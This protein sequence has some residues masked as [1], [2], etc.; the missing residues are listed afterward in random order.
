MEKAFIAFEKVRQS[1][2]TNMYD[3]TY[4]CS[5]AGITVEEYHY[6]LENYTELLNQFN[7]QLKSEETKFELSDKE[8]F[9]SAYD[10]VKE[11]E[12]RYGLDYDIV[13][14]GVSMKR[15]YDDSD[16]LILSKGVNHMDKFLEFCDDNEIKEFYITNKMMDEE[17]TNILSCVALNDQYNFSGTEFERLGQL[18]ELLFKFS[19]KEVA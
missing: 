8:K 16:K 14:N 1:G 9:M 7:E 13:E 19:I 5:L 10:D 2:V 18:T 11:L 3:R 6:I 15:Y 17:A 12:V 4:V